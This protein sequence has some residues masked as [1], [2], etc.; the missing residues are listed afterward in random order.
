[1]RG[2]C[3]RLRWPRTICLP[4][5]GLQGESDFF[6]VR[7]GHITADALED[8]DPIG[9]EDRVVITDRPGARRRVEDVEQ[10]HGVEAI[11]SCGIHDLVDIR[12]EPQASQIDLEGILDFDFAFQQARSRRISLEREGL[13]ALCFS[14]KLF[15]QIPVPLQRGLVGLSEKASDVL[16]VPSLVG[17]QVSRGEIRIVAG[18]SRIAGEEEGAPARCIVGIQ[19]EHTKIECVEILIG[20]VPEDVFHAAPD[21]RGH[22]S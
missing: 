8:L 9:I 1:M 17:D 11:S 3:L 15:L 13:D 2:S 16:V 7:Q 19:P 4:H 22:P 5:N 14:E 10:N 18:G 12:Q 20:P 6:S 21:Q